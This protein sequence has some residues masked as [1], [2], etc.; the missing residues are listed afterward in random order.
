MIPDYLHEDKKAKDLILFG[1]N[2]HEV[3]AIGL[4]FKPIMDF[5]KQYAA[6]INFDFAAQCDNTGLDA[7]NDNVRASFLIYQVKHNNE[8]AGPLLYHALFVFMHEKELDPL[9]FSD[10]D[11]Y[12]YVLGVT[13]AFIARSA[14]YQE[15]RYQMGMA[16]ILKALKELE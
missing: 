10:E 9:V 14:A 1:R 16:S 6:E 8:D 5:V 15:Y 13:G 12:Y 11:V 7:R 2:L 4:S 3:M